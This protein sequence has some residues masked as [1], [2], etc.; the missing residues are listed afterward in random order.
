MDRRNFKKDAHL[1]L[2]ILFDEEINFIYPDFNLIVQVLDVTFEDIHENIVFE[3]KK[4][5]NVNRIDKNKLYHKFDVKLEYFKKIYSI[6]IL[7]DVDKNGKISLGD[8]ISMDR[9]DF[10]PNELVH[11]ISI[12]VYKVTS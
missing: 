10:M 6:F 12:K 11:N 9:H 3:T 2:T 1:N 8:Y 7:I 5:F 4:P